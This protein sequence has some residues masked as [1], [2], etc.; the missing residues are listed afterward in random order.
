MRLFTPIACLFAGLIACPAIPLLA[1][2]SPTADQL[3]F[4]EKKVRPVLASTCYKCH[5]HGGEKLKAN[6]FLD[7]RE[8]MLKGGENGPAI[9]PG[10][11]SRSLLI[12]AVKWVNDDLQMPPKNKLSDSAIADFVTWV[13]M[14]APWP[15]EDKVAAAPNY[16]ADYDRIRKELWS[17]QPIKNT[18]PPAVKDAKWCKSDI[19]RFVLA[20]LDEKGMAPSA[21]ADKLTLLRRATYD[22]TGLPPTPEEI[23]AFLRDT[24]ADAFAK[25]VDRL[26]ASPRYGERWGRHWL[27][28]A[29]YAE[30]SGMTR[31]LI[32]KYA[33]RYRDYVIQAFNEDKPYDRFITEQLAGDLL[34]SRG[35][36]DKDNLQVATGFLCVGTRD[37]NE[38]KPRQFN[39][40]V[41]DE[42][43]D[44]VGR[45][46]LATTIA[47]ARCHDHKFDPI[48]TAD[49]YSM[50]GIFISS[51]E[52]TG[53]ILRR[54]ATFNQYDEDQ[55]VR[56]A[57]YKPDPA[58][59]KKADVTADPKDIDRAAF[60]NFFMRMRSSSDFAKPSTPIK[61]LAMGVREDSRPGNVNILNR[62]EID[63]P[64][65]LVKRGFLS[66]PAIK[67]PPTIS[68]GQSGRWDLARW[69][70]K[71]DNPLTARVMA[72]RI[73]GHLFGHAIVASVDNFGTTGEKPTHPELLDHL[74]AQFMHDGW[75]VK[76]LIRSIMLSSAYQQSAAF[77]KAKYA[78]DPD[79]H[80]LWRQNQR[81]LE[82]EAIRDAMLAA[83][84]KIN[85]AP[86][87]ASIALDFPETPLGA[88]GGR[89]NFGELIS[90]TS[91][92]SVY[93]P[94]LRNMLPEA[95]DVFD[96]A[97]NA[98]VTGQRDVT[99]VAPQALYML[100][101]TFVIHMAQAMTDRIATARLPTDAARVEMA[102]KLT[103]GRP[104]SS[105]ERDRALNYI[106]VFL[107]DPKAATSRDPYTNKAAAWSSLCQA[108][109]AS[110][111]FRYLN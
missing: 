104:A 44:T 38:R 46:F 101:N 30:S 78:I 108:L 65:Q 91:H 83:S 93:L 4:F 56:L 87:V 69:I 71:S 57:D 109:F 10:S 6:L 84:G 70:T 13:D 34:P 61:P 76:S 58:A 16:A 75:S 88:G 92:R 90:N 77:D 23:D 24:S 36:K 47:C 94:I 40:N 97:D 41:A 35:S 67:D 48:P 66:I 25:V 21:P 80:N 53:I 73:W 33:W 50:A 103:L 86:P 100:N 31:N 72:N 89:F 17:W 59:A 39:Y 3:A 15:K 5:S 102:Y 37:Y 110:A 63:Q 29:R 68:S 74:A 111:E 95:L 19:D 106:Q 79:N 55:L 18:E 81:R 105:T 82:A 60:R 52:Y 2:D 62:G 22:L 99:T 32:Y 12:K 11:A 1:A 85:L 51:Q 14:G 64:G 8:G 27:D 96:F 7:S 28:V 20:K 98:N 49:Y 43:I 107:R 54:G 26:L 42:Q 45:A 9:V